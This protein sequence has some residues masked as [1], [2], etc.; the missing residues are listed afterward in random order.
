MK[1]ESANHHVHKYIREY[2]CRRG[3]MEMLVLCP[4]AYGS[5][6]SKLNYP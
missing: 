4:I 3:G 2:V 6:K 5:L 1:E